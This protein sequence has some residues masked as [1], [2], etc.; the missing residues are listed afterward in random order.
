MASCK[1][2]FLCTLCIPVLYIIFF[3]LTKFLF[4][5]DSIALIYMKDS[6]LR[7]MQG[8][9]V[10]WTCEIHGAQCHNTARIHVQVTTF[11]S[12]FFTNRPFQRKKTKHCHLLMTQIRCVL[13]LYIHRIFTVNQKYVQVCMCTNAGKGTLEWEM[14][15]TLKLLLGSSHFFVKSTLC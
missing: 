7:K 6:A 14:L 1:T 11:F 15:S 10:L 2:K 13:S 3:S 5:G 12:F 4:W 9:Q 8:S